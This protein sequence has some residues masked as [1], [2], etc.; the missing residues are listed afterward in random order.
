MWVI[1]E[2]AEVCEQLLGMEGGWTRNNPD[3]HDA[4]SNERLAEELGDA[5]MMCMVAGI[6]RGLDPFEAMLDKMAGKMHMERAFVEFVG[7][8]EQ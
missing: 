4:P 6:V 8:D 2:I 1:T 3:D 5:I 7:E